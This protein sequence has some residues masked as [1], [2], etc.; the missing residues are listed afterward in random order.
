[1]PTQK[2]CAKEGML[3][4]QHPQTCL[5][6]DTEHSGTCDPLTKE[7]ECHSMYLLLRKL[8]LCLRRNTEMNFQVSSFSGPKSDLAFHMGGQ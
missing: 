1:M 5:G 3:A 7:G 6:D 2:D 4:T 8:L